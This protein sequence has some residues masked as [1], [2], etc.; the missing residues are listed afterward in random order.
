M[1]IFHLLQ[2]VHIIVEHTIIIQ[3]QFEEILLF[4]TI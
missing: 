1:I 2:L 3:F 4:S